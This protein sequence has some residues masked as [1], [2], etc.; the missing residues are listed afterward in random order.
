MY[1]LTCSSFVTW[2]FNLF[3]AKLLR[4][5]PNMKQVHSDPQSL[6]SFKEHCDLKYSQDLSEKTEY[7]KRYYLK[8]EFVHQKLSFFDTK[9]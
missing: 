5:G 6:G 3:I 8:A 9:W 4:S 2:K 1:Y 7:F